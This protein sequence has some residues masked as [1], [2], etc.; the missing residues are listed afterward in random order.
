MT[1]D[2]FCEAVTRAGHET[3]ISLVSQCTGWYAA[4]ESI[5][6]PAIEEKKRL[7]HQLQDTHDLTDDE[8]ADLKY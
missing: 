3:A 4:S 2:A 1:Y 7:R 6:H 5:L 8:I